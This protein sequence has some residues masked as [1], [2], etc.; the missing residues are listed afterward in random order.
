MLPDRVAPY[1]KHPANASNAVVDSTA[2]ISLQGL[3][4]STGIDP[5]C[6]EGAVTVTNDGLSSAD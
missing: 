6:R 3:Y 4:R 2:L 5:G 1:L